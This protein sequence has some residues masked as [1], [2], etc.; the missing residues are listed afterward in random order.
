MSRLSILK[1]VFGPVIIGLLF[2]GLAGGVAASQGTAYAADDGS[3]QVAELKIAAL[4]LD[5]I[6]SI[7]NDALT[8]SGPHAVVLGTGESGS[9]LARFRGGSASEWASSYGDLL[10]LFMSAVLGFCVVARRR[11]SVYPI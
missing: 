6:G 8:L 11:S 7:S 3:G 4:S 10:W 5:R 2:A 1:G 9:Q